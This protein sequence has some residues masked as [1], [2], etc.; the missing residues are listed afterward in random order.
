LIECSSIGE[1]HGLSGS[2]P[3][4][5]NG[6][7]HKFYPFRPTVVPF[8]GGGTVGDF[9]LPSEPCCWIRVIHRNFRIPRYFHSWIYAGQF[10]TFM[11]S[12]WQRAKNLTTL[13]PTC[14][15]VFQVHN[16]SVAC[17]AF[18]EAH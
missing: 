10:S 11:P 14:F 2:R 3:Q 9:I 16:V 7:A 6:S 5:T 17:F 18:E 13:R 12:A 4:L 8:R 15:D 1:T